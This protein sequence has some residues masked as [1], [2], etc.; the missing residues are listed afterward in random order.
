MIKR[1]IKF[2]YYDKGTRSRSPL[3]LSD[4]K[5]LAHQREMEL[6]ASGELTQKKLKIISMIELITSILWQAFLGFCVGYTIID[7]LGGVH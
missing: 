5:K 3:F 4:K 2:K 1:K 6:D 7:M